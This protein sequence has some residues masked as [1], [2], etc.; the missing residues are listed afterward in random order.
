MEKTEVAKILFQ[1][2]HV[3]PNFC[4]DYSEEQSEFILDLWTDHLKN[5]KKEIVDLVVYNWIEESKYYPNIRDI[6]EKIREEE[7]KQKWEAY[8]DN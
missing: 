1:L 6:K 7:S 4:K 3:Y 2:R 8:Y 5:E